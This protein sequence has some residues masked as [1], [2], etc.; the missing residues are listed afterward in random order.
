VGNGK[1]QFVE[2][3]DCEADHMFKT[4]FMFLLDLCF[5]LNSSKEFLNSLTKSTVT[6]WSNYHPPLLV[7]P[8]LLMKMMSELL[9]LGTG[10]YFE[11]VE[12]K[13]VLFALLDNDRCL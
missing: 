12:S 11:M 2:S 8:P 5:F 10:L 13:A 3:E 4:K 7:L 9:P 1:K 6:R